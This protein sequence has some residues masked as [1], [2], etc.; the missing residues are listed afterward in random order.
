ML[1]TSEGTGGG[2]GYFRTGWA[3]CDNN[4]S[5]WGVGS[6]TQWNVTPD[7]YLGLEVAYQR[8]NTAT[9]PFGFARLRQRHQAGCG[10]HGRRPGKL[11]GSLPRSQGL[12][13]LIG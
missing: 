5:F 7:T 8:L 13:S 11:D 3:G 2:L 10:L 1:C 6:R 4:W 9:M 12:L